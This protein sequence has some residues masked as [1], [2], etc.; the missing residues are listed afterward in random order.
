MSHNSPHIAT[1][2]HLPL[3]FGLVTPIMSDCD[4]LIINVFCKN[5]KEE[6][7]YTA[8]IHL[9]NKKKMLEVC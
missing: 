7:G 3:I 2:P 5:K 8:T 6:P 1:N 4:Y 9:V